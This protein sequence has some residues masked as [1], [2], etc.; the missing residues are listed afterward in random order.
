MRSTQVNW[1]SLCGAVLNASRGKPT[2]RGVGTWLTTR[3]AREVL[4]GTYSLDFAP[5]RE[6]AEILAVRAQ[7]RFRFD[8][9]VVP[10]AAADRT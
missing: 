9:A 7:I 2:L 6:D 5:K 1:T 10:S 8:G 3:I 4:R